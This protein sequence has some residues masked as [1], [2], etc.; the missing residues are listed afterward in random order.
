MQ[1]FD[2]VRIRD[3]KIL[4]FILF[5]KGGQNVKTVAI[6]RPGR[7]RV[8]EIGLDLLE[9][10]LVVCLGAQWFDVLHHTAYR[11][12]SWIGVVFGR[13]TINVVSAVSNG[14]RRSTIGAAPMLSIRAEPNAANARTEAGIAT[15]RHNAAI[16]A[17]RGFMITVSD[18]AGLRSQACGT[19]DFWH[20]DGKSNGGKYA[21]SVLRTRCCSNATRRHR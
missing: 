14:A 15:S 10:P 17:N 11:S 4:V 1:K 16:D 9:G 12:S 19:D 21:Y 20:L 5:E 3:F 6:L 7:R 8:F 13:R 18:W 2:G